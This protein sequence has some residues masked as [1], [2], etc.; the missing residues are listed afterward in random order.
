MRASA[1]A[2]ARLV[3]GL[4]GGVREPAVAGPDRR[5][6][7]A[8]GP[9]GMGHPSIQVLRNPWVSYG[10]PLGWGALLTHAA[11]T[12]VKPGFWGKLTRLTRARHGSIGGSGGGGGGGSDGPGIGV[13]DRPAKVPVGATTILDCMGREMAKLTDA[14]QP[15]LPLDAY[16]AHL[17]DA[18][19]AS[20]DHRF[21]SHC[22]VDH[23]T[24]F[25]QVVSA[26][27]ARSRPGRTFATKSTGGASTI[28]QQLAK[29]NFLVPDAFTLER[30]LVQVY[31]ALM[32]EARLSKAEILAAYLSKVYVGHG[33]TGMEAAA[34]KYFGKKDPRDLTLGE[35]AMLAG[36]LPAPEDWSPYRDMQRARAVQQAVLRKMLRRGVIGV[37]EFTEAARAP[38]R[39]NA[40]PPSISWRAPYFTDEVV[41]QLDAHFDIGEILQGGF[42]VHTT[43]DLDLQEYAERL[44]QE[45]QRDPSVVGG[46]EQACIVAMEPKSG[47]VQVLVGGVDYSKSPWNRATDMFRSPGSTFKSIVYLAGLE[48]GI[49]TSDMLLDQP[50][51]FHDF[52]PVNFDAKFRGKVT[53]EQA[54][55]QS[56]NVPTCFL[57]A[58]IGVSAVKHMAHILGIESTLDSGLGLCLG[59]CEVSPLELTTAYSTIAAGGVYSAPYLISRIEHPDGRVLLEHDAAA[60]QQRVVNGNS[61]ARLNYLLRAV[62]ERGTGGR[63][64]IDRPVAGKTGTSNNHIDTWFSGYTPQ[65]AC[66]VWIGRDDNLPL[67]GRPTGG[68]LAAPLFAA[69]MRFAHEDCRGSPLPLAGFLELRDSRKDDEKA[70]REELKRSAV[71]R[72]KRL[73]PAF[74]EADVPWIAGGPPPSPAYAANSSLST[75]FS[76]RDALGAAGAA[77]DAF[78][79]TVKFTSRERAEATRSVRP[80]TP[81]PKWRRRGGRAKKAERYV[82]PMAR[83]PSPAPA[84]RHPDTGHI[85]VP[86]IPKVTP[87]LH[88][89]TS[90]PQHRADGAR[91]PGEGDV[92]ESPRSERRPRGGDQARHSAPAKRR[93]R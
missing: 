16:P 91:M 12:S 36:L 30:K 18:V 58:R 83:D 14:D 24:L 56:L 52:I 3:P 21:F 17:I 63:A 66:S 39:L 11:G 5:S 31:L 90:I 61:V 4:E 71:I 42:R 20:E 77:A 88:P 43:C 7:G 22:G 82:S 80:H 85:E 78:T 62:V 15:V 75:A 6:V 84:G 68:T 8:P 50:I 49:K 69:F 47:A 72:K 37:D 55:V 60:S 70:D 92:P 64:V 26:V 65:L 57:G 33:A 48:D 40:R 79:D 51:D 35:S 45:R 46:D 81:S 25:R 74:R 38:I 87:G 34:D 13:D 89:G 93:P 86:A 67:H 29:V 28:S 19:V 54:L 73:S 1:G 76:Q 10:L 41:H 23:L 53:V 2:L 32:L 44:V 59:G 27:A 9:R